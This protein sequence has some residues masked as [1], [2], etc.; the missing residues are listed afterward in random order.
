MMVS[1]PPLQPVLNGLSDGVALTGQKASRNLTTKRD[2]V[3]RR[4]IRIA[5]NACE[6]LAQ[7]VSFGARAQH[8]AGERLNPGGSIAQQYSADVEVF[9]F[10]ASEDQLL[11]AQQT[12]FHGEDL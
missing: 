4:V 7:D 2:G 3:Y 1:F 10:L 12:G 6:M 9:R 11:A 5:A 8:R